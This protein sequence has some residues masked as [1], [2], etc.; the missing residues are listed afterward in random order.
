ML[1][2]IACVSVLFLGWL[3]CL[4]EIEWRSVAGVVTDKRGNALPG[5]EVQLEDSIALSV[6]SYIT[7]DD[8]RYHFSRVNANIDYTLKA[9]YRQYWS[10]PKALSQFNSA[11]HAR[12]DL[13]IPIE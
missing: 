7:R 12:V 6:R 13:V 1:K 2:R 10:K 8:G 5:A 3:P 9:K 11:E 4:P